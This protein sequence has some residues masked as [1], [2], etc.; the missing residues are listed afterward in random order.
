MMVSVLFKEIMVSVFFDYHQGNNGVSSFVLT[1]IILQT[2]R[3]LGRRTG[4]WDAA[5]PETGTNR[6]LEPE[7]G[8]QLTGN[9]DAA[10]I[11]AES[12]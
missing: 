11:G 1:T 6:K 12:A 10:S 9:W 2:N 4:N 3:K 8:T 5:K 7:T